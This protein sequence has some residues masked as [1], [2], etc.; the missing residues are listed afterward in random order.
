M[1]VFLG[2]T[3]VMQVWVLDVK[4]HHGVADETIYDSFE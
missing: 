3:L 4:K 2:A 1:L